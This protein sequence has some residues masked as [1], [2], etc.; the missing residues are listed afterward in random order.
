MLLKGETVL[1]SLGL[2]A[3]FPEGGCLFLGSF[4]FSRGLCGSRLPPPPL[5]RAF[6]RELVGTIYI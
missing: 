1:V 3:G 4:A 5:T 6:E 2:I